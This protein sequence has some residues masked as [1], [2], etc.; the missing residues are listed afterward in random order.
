MTTRDRQRGCLFSLTVGDAP[1]AAVEFSQPRRF[2][3]VTGY[4]GGGPHGL[5]AGQC[6]GETTYMEHRV[7]S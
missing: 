1:G 3:L 6:S 4:R 5:A 2:E 7:H